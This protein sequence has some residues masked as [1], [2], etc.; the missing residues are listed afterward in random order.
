MRRLGALNM[1]G[2]LDIIVTF[3]NGAKQTVGMLNAIRTFQDG[4]DLEPTNNLFFVTL[5][6]VFHEHTEHQNDSISK[7]L[8]LRLK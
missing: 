1:L 6:Q 2:M 3:E 5:A 8:L 4:A 7:R